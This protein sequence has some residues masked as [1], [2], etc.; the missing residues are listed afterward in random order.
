MKPLTALVL[1][2]AGFGLYLLYDINSFKWNKGVL[3]AGFFAGTLLIAAATLLLVLEAW[4]ADA[5]TAGDTVLIA[6]AAIAFAALIYCLFFALPFDETYSKQTSGRA[7]YTCGAYALCRHPGIICF[8]VFYLFLG[9][10]A[11]P[12]KGLLGCG[13]LFS[14]LNLA[15]AWFQDAVTFP[16]VFTGYEEYRGTTPF[17]IPSAKSIKRARQTWGRP[18]GKEED[19]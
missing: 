14:A 11:L 16:R 2:I 5:F 1:G 18:Y 10:A 4:R 9:L 19:L 15:Y 3:K 8:F 6:A 13:M 12:C 7:V 17:L